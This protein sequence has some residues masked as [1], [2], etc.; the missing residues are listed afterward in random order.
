MTYF[1]TLDGGFYFFPK[2]IYLIYLG[3]SRPI[4]NGSP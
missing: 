4:C 3:R 1:G 2:H